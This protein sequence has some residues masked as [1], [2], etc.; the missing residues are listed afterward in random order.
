[1][2]LREGDATTATPLLAESLALFRQMGYRRGLLQCLDGFAALHLLRGDLARAI[3]LLSAT[4]AAM[5]RNETFLEKVDHLEFEEHLAKARALAE[6]AMW[7][8]AWAEGQGMTIEEGID[9]ALEF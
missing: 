6:E 5:D 1:V 4:Q 3:N 2:I 9:H 7:C 8:G